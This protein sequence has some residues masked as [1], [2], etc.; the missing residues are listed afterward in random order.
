MIMRL[1]AINLV[2]IEET[3]V[4]ELVM[5]EVSKQY[6]SKFPHFQGVFSEILLV[7]GSEDVPIFSPKISQQTRFF[8]PRWD[9]NLHPT[10]PLKAVILSM[11]VSGSP[12]RW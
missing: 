1:T 4:E 10:L 5:V 11:V 7:V 2:R 6:S 3:R 8:L 12:K 9:A